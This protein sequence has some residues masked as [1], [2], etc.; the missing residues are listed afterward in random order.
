MFGLPVRIQSMVAHVVKAT[1]AEISL[2]IAAKA[3]YLPGGR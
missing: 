1:D 3:A 2:L